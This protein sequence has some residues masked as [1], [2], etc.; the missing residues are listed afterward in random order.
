MVTK[1][2]GHEVERVRAWVIDKGVT[3]TRNL[4]VCDETALF[5]MYISQKLINILSQNN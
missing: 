3:K 4:D 2:W 1:K 5:F